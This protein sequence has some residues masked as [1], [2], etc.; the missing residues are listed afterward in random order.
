MGVSLYTSR[1]V[2]Q[3]LGVSDYGIYGLVGGFVAMFSFLNYAMSSA[4]QRYLSFDIGKGD[5]ERLRKTFSA[6]LTIHVGIALLVLLLAETLGLWY[7]NYKMVFPEERTFAVN[8]VYQFSVASSLLGIIQVP[9]NSLI[10]ARER[11]SVYAYVGII[12]VFFKLIIVFLLVY[13]GSDKLI[14]YSVLTFVVAFIIRMIYQLYCRKHFKESIYHF[15][16]DKD[17]YKELISY[18]GWNLFENISAVA[19]GQGSNVVL[20]IFFGV[21]ANAAYGITAV[22]QVAMSSLIR[23]FQIAVNPQITISY[24]RGEF[25]TMQNL[26]NQSSKFSFLMALLL[27]SPILLNIDFILK[28]WLENPPLYASEMIFF[29]L[30]C[31]LVDTLSGSLNTAIQA[32]GK[33]KA[34]QVVIGTLVLINLPIS[35][36]LF[37]NEVTDLPSVIFKIWLILSIISLFF[38][39]Y[40]LK[41]LLDFN[42]IIFLKEVL[43][44]VVVVVIFSG[45]IGY[46]LKLIFIEKTFIKVGAETLIY[47]ILLAGIIYFLVLNQK[48]KQFIQ[49]LKNKFISSKL[50][51]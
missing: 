42:I 37:K 23:N 13:F 21:V 19:R 43:A 29:C 6:A 35:Y 26:V 9:Y 4:T 48:E 20:N 51:L 7:V 18:S 1:V 50:K 33:I 28:I 27:I 39:L 12:E 17:Y 10:I 22:V 31:L 5:Y 8:V 16:Y 47:L 3:V 34:Y 15:K 25:K 38:R 24:A 45:I 46:G 11:M 32:T 40:F 2:L 49:Q 36:L 41:K 44:K 14:T 30:L